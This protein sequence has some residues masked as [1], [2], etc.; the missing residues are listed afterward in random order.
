MKLRILTG[1][2]ASA[3]LLCTHTALAFDL[4]SALNTLSNVKKGE[5]TPPAEKDQ[6]A[7]AFGLDAL[8][9]VTQSTSEEEEV[10]IG[11]EIA[12]RLLGAA[13]LVADAKL[14]KYV[15]EVGQWVAAQSERSD[16][17][18]TFGVI[19]SPAINAFAAPG[20][21]IFLTRGLYVLIKSEAE[22]A[23][24][25]GHEIGHVLKQHHL[26]ILNQSKL[27]NSGSQLV[28]A[29]V[30]NRNE[31]T[32]SLI[33]SG[34][35]ILSRGLDKDAE[36]EADRIGMVLAARAGY[37]AYGLPAVLQEIG[38]ISAGTDSVELLFKTHPHPNDR[39][40]ALD[41][42][43]GDFPDGGD[44]VKKRFYKLKP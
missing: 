2:L 34:A 27:L 32:D 33:G 8:K 4:G 1:T 3:L 31:I 29:H 36:Y 40:E 43:M 12:G 19:D 38:H 11:R 18:W 41:L 37:N 39:L 17:K 24:V 16:L 35:E 25:L 14:Q 5:N 20:G 21:Y 44:E 7:F 28:S 42:S 10:A 9:A 22:L 6:K 30:K 26:K 15:N 13:P 23:G